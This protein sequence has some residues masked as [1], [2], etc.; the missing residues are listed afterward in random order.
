MS[1]QIKKKFLRADSVD[2]RKVLFLNNEAFRTVKADGQTEMSLFKLDSS[3]RFQLLTLP[4]VSVDPA[5]ANDVVRKSYVNAEDLKVAQEAQ[6][7]A[8]QQVQSE[9][10]ER[11]TQDALIRSE[12]EA[13]D[14]SLKQ[15][16][17]ASIAEVR[18]DF[19]NADLIITNMIS[20]ES[21]LRVSEDSRV[22]SEAKA[23]A[24]SK[25]QSFGQNYAIESFSVTQQILDQKYIELSNKAFR[26]SIVPTIARL[27]LLDSVDFDVEVVG[28]KTR[29]VFK[30]SLLPLTGAEALE[31][32]DLVIVRYLK[33]V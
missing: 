29:L 26:F 20:E 25:S 4:Q 11:E 15:E 17:E 32:G 5:A 14:A 27:M 19:E 13:A 8:D 7:Y 6:S 1:N 3:D 24:D 28:T 33:E 31:L 16:L 22:L 12:Y 30:N 10:Q 21:S 2:G 23:Y 18:T 9:A